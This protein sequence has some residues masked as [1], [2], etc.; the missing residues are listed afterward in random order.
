MDPDRVDFLTQPENIDELRSL[1][2][3]HVIPGLTLAG[4]FTAGPTETLFTGNDVEVSIDPLVF[5][6]SGVVTVD[7]PGSNG[8]YNTIDRVLDP[9]VDRKCGC[10]QI[11][12]CLSVLELTYQLH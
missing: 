2:L 4:D 3:Y 1:L 12:V 9:F 11:D 6:F 7:T 5:D 10:S 8:V